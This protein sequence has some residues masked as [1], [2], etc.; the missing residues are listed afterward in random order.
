LN[1]SHQ[2]GRQGIIYIISPV[3]SPVLKGATEW[4]H[5][6]ALLFENSSIFPTR[7]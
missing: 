5:L 7:D 1:S 6:W 3:S 4:A 2:N